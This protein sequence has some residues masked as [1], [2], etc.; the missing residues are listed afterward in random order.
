MIKRITFTAITVSFLLGFYINA[1]FQF[2]RENPDVALSFS[3]LITF[4]LCSSLLFIILVGLGMEIK[5]RLKIK[6]DLDFYLNYVLFFFLG[7]GILQCLVQNEIVLSLF[8]FIGGLVYLYIVLLNYHQI[9]RKNN[10][11]FVKA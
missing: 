5:K 8:G 9:L 2:I 4:I 3:H 1:N 10:S 11:T 7:M 6:A